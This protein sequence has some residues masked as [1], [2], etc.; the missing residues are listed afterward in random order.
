VGLTDPAETHARPDL[1][2]EYR[3]RSGWNTWISGRF[4]L[5]LSFSPPSGLLVTTLF[6]TTG[7]IFVFFLGGVWI[8]FVV[9]FVFVLGL[10]LMF[11]G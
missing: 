8:V 2:L 10:E 5:P 7:H 1:L 6:Q 4:S 9:H 3:E 11:D